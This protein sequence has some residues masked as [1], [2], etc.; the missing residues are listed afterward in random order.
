MAKL[1]HIPIQQIDDSGR[2]RQEYRDI[3]ELA[4]SIKEKGL[5]Q[6][7]TVRKNG[8]GFKLLAGGRRFRACQ[9]A[10]LDSIPA[11]LR[12]EGEARI[13]DLEVE[14]HENLNRDDLTWVEEADLVA[15]IDAYYRNKFGDKWKDS[16]TAEVLNRSVGGVNTLL[17]LNRAVKLIPELTN[18]KTKDEAFKKYKKLEEHAIVKHLRGQQSKDLADYREAQQNDGEESDD[19]ESPREPTPEDP[20]LILLNNADNHFQLGDAFT[21]LEELIEIYRDQP[22]PI[23]LFEID[24]P[25]AIDLH[26]QKQGK[27]KKDRPLLKEYQEVDADEYSAFLERLCTLTF[28]AAADDCWII[29]WHG[30]TWH[31]EVKQALL[32]AGFSVDEIPAIWNKGTGQTN[33]PDVYLGRA[34]ETFFIARK[35]QPMLR[36]EG[37]TNVFTFSPVAS[38]KKYH[39]TQRPIPLMEEIIETFIYPRQVACSPFLGSGA[40]LKAAYRQNVMAFGWDLSEKHKDYFMASLEDDV[41]NQIEEKTEDE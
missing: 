21:G 3:E 40:F 11:I 25:Y 6:P 35:G 32:K 23:K 34:Y 12:E 9:L 1:I 13:D 41:L 14:L 15:R 28:Q 27:D 7:I 16:K 26:N 38:K 20:R 18:V 19:S 24:P 17:Q 8:N 22:S 37:R 4:E 39:P 33:R 2:A 36:K 5:I 10:D 30:P 29:F 31:Y